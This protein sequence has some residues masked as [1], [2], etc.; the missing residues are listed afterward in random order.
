VHLANARDA[1]LNAASASAA[2]ASAL[3]ENSIL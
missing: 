2:A 3:R 1:T